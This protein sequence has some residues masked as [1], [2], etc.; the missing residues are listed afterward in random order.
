MTTPTPLMPRE[1]VPALD[2]PLVGGRHHVLGAKPA[3]RF[4]LVVFYRGLHTRS[5]RNICWSSSGLRPGLKSSPAS[6]WSSQTARSTT[7]RR[8][9]CR[10]PTCLAPST[11][12]FLPE[13]SGHEQDLM[14]PTD[15]CL[16]FH[17]C[18]GCNA[19]PSPM[20]GDRCV[21]CSD[22]S[23]RCPPKQIEGGACCALSSGDDARARAAGVHSLNQGEIP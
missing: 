16:F 1:S 2:L 15:S 19:L 9:R 14:I 7:E 21:F 6:F 17:Q 12:R 3:A 20:P 13:L 5:G 18:A 4:D 8:K 10:S 11:A 22:G 23:A